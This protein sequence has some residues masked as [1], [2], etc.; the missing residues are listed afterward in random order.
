MF[1]DEGGGDGTARAS[2]GPIRTGR[3]EVGAGAGSHA[4]LLTPVASAG[5]I[6]VIADS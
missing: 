5:L 2:R 4:R 1:E 6:R 3:A